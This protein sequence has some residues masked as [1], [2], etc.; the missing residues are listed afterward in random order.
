MVDSSSG[1]IVQQFEAAVGPLS[2]TADG[3]ILVGV[4]ANKQAFVWNLTDF[5]LLGSFSFAPVAL[6]PD[7]EFNIGR[8]SSEVGTEMVPDD[9]QGIWFLLPGMSP[10]RWDLNEDSWAE[11]AC[12]QVGRGMTPQEWADT[13]GTEMPDNATCSASGL[14]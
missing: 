8:V 11:I 6:S 7:S 12:G 10:T 4:G 13:V 2:C 9:H 14:R 3:R 5:A 1:A